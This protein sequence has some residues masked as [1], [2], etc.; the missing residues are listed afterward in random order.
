M[1]RLTSYKN[2]CNR[3]MICRYEDCDTCEEYCPDINED[4]CPCLQEVIKKL[5]EYEDLEEQ[6]KL[7]KLPCAV[8]DMV[9]CVDSY[10][11]GNNWQCNYR[12]HFCK[13]CCLKEK[14]VNKRKFTLDMFEK[15]GKIVFITQEEAEAALSELQR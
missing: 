6:G 8:G 5:A 10:C 11:N 1:E 14:S 13:D 2:E 4:N 9:Y 7:L 15:F 12:P 3:E